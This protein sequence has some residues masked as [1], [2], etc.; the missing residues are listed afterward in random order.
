M[1][2][3]DLTINGFE[4]TVGISSNLMAAFFQKFSCININNK[5][6]SSITFP[7]GDIRLES[8]AISGGNIVLTDGISFEADDSISFE[9]I[10]FH[11]KLHSI[12]CVRKSTCLI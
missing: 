8:L 4:D 5:S 12:C 1:T 10:K 2:Y 7:S 3:L 11:S 6:I 9:S